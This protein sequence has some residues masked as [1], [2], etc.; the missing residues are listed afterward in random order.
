MYILTIGYP[1]AA[2]ARQAAANLKAQFGQTA[3]VIRPIL[4]KTVVVRILKE[5]MGMS[6]IQ[7]PLPTDYLGNVV[8]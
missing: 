2:D 8:L 5:G 1:R 6:S 3:E 7:L 4:G